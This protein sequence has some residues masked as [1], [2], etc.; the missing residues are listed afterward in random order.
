MTVTKVAVFS[1]L[2][3]WF[4]PATSERSEWGCWFDSEEHAQVFTPSM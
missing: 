2:R 1:W 3:D 4:G